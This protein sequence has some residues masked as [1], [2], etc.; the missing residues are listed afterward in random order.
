MTTARDLYRDLNLEEGA[1]IEEIKAAYRMMAKSYHPDS[2]SARDNAS[3]EKFRKA[4]EAYKGLLREAM[5][6]ASEVEKKSR[7]EEV[8]DCSPYVFSAK[9]TSGLN[10]FYDLILERP[11]AGRSVRISLPVVR[12]EACPRCLG[13]GSALRRQGGGFVYK[14]VACDRCGGSGYEERELQIDLTLTP[15]MLERGKVRVRSM[16]AYDHKEGKRGDL[17]VNLEFVE[18]L[19]R[20]N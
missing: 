7:S 11:Q 8:T 18:T 14:P 13:H 6:G 15:G 12:G 1:G 2:V 4:Y 5:S 17:V 3:P 9:R 20:N 16:G 19:P 10:V